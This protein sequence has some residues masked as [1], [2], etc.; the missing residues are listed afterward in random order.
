MCES[1][2]KIDSWDVSYADM[3]MVDQDMETDSDNLWKEYHKQVLH[4]T[5]EELLEH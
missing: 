5:I 1:G 2:K 4:V 3:Q